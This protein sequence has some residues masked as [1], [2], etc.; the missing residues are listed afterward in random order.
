M[1]ENF[2]VGA[3]LGKGFSIYA[4]NFIPFTLIT[5][6]VYL[7]LI[8]WT[9]FTFSS[10][11]LTVD[12]I[13]HWRYLEPVFK[14]VVTSFVSATLTYGVVKQLQGE[15]ASF[16]ACISVGFTR[17]LPALGV[18]VMSAIAFIGGFILLFVPGVIVLCMLYVATPASVIEKPGVF[19]ALR[20]SR[21]L[22]AGYKGH[23]F[24]ILLILGIVGFGAVKIV[25]AS[26]TPLTSF[27]SIRTFIMVC[28]GVD[29]LLA[30]LGSCFAAV[31]Y[32]LLRGE[33]E[34]T[35]ANDL[36]SVFE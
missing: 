15:K 36:A 30:A 21:E 11:H 24:G 29:V 28:V 12:Q 25:E 2:G 34:G 16:G 5:A 23:I 3:V 1:N 17:M 35:S 32:T 22:T 6:I 31:A 18:G 19:G 33:K 7:P 27:S 9:W 20:R 14:L 4:K 10:D 13:N 26:F 8:L